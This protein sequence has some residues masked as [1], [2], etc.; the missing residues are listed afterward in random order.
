M[1]DKTITQYY[2]DDHDRLDGL[3]GQFQALKKSDAA[4]ARKCFGQFKA[5]LERHMAWEEEILFPDFEAKTGM[6]DAGPTQVMRMEHQQIRQLLGSIAAHQGV[7][8]EPEETQLL[9]TLGSH[10]QKEEQIL[11]PAIDQ[12]VSAEERRGIYLRMET[13]AAP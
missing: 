2:S 11:Y 13:V 4:N 9:E 6:R 12:R 3:F 8:T 10:N 7:G 5:G 1:S